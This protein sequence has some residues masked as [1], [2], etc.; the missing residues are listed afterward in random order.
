MMNNWGDAAAMASPPSLMFDA[1]LDGRSFAAVESSAL[2][3]GDPFSLGLPLLSLGDEHRPAAASASVVSSAENDDAGSLSATPLSPGE[4]QHDAFFDSAA[5]AE[6]DL[7]SP[8]SYSTAASSSAEAA[9]AFRGTTPP[10]V[11][12]AVPRPAAISLP[13]A[14]SAAASRAAAAGPF[15]VAEDAS[16]SSRPGSAASVAPATVM[17]TRVKRPASAAARRTKRQKTAR[18]ASAAA[19]VPSA[20]PVAAVADAADEAG[21]KQPRTAAELHAQR[22]RKHNI[23]ELKR[24][25]RMR[26]HFEQLDSLCVDVH[27]ASSAGT[28]SK[29]RNN[30]D[31][32]SILVAAIEQLRIYREQ[33][34]CLSADANPELRLDADGVVTGGTEAAAL[35]SAAA[36]GQSISEGVHPA[37]LQGLHRAFNR[38]LAGESRSQSLLARVRSPNG[39]FV[40]HRLLVAGVLSGFSLLFFD[41]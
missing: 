32:D 19:A 18:P 6:N 23:I 26:Q 21:A 29:R 8:S 31:K 30:K 1:P 35:V 10:V 3:K 17:A 28:G 40:Q 33:L 37:D 20:S 13:H 7:M 24:R 11:A 12:T 15:F 5:A 4:F 34:A 39:Q 36:T 41:A 22:R 16:T 38:I 25:E 14:S 9:L 2:A 27:A